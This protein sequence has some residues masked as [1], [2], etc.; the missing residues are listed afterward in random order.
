MLVAK[1]LYFSVGGSRLTAA[2]SDPEIAGG[3]SRVDSEIVSQ[4]QTHP[5]RARATA[6]SSGGWG[7]LAE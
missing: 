6:A 5:R 7:G 2:E 1:H 3:R 4:A